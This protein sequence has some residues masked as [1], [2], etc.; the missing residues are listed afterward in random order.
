M[1]TLFVYGTLQH[2]DLLRSLIGAHGA[3]R[4]ARLPGYRAAPLRGRVYPG[5]VPLPDAGA[6]GDL[7]AGPDAGPDAGAAGHLVDVDEAA[8]GILDAFEGD[9]Y[10]RVAVDALELDTPGRGTSEGGAPELG[11]QEVDGAVV[12]VRAEAWLLVGP[13]RRLAEP[14]HWDF[15]AFVAHDADAFLGGA[16]AGD[17]HP[18]AGP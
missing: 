15:A 8:V 3:L 6:E 16:R 2:P 14:G 10:R 5:L 7:G 11:R 4:P 9:Q 17:A 18:G 13:A 12:P 1:P